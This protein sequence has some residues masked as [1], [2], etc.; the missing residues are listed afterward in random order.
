MLP[1]LLVVA[2]AS[3]DVNS[4][5]ASGFQLDDDGSCSDSSETCLSLLQRRGEKA[6]KHLINSNSVQEEVYKPVRLGAHSDLG[7]A[8]PCLCLFDTD[9]TLTA[10]QR[11][12]FEP[13]YELRTYPT[14]GLEAVDAVCDGSLSQP[15]SSDT[16]YPRNFSEAP[17]TMR[18]SGLTV[19]FDD[20]F[21]SK[22]CYKGILS[23]G[24]IGG[25]LLHDPRKG[26][27]NMVETLEF[28]LNKGPP[29]FRLPCSLGGNGKECSIDALDAL[30]ATDA[31]LKPFIINI[32]A[33]CYQKDRTL[34]KFSGVCKVDFVKHVIAY[35]RKYANI[36]IPDENVHFYDDA[37]VNVAAFRGSKYRAHQIACARRQCWMEPKNHPDVNN[38]LGVCGATL[39]EIEAS[40]TGP[41][42]YLC[43]VDKDGNCDATF[44]CG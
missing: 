29:E 35:Y 4:E 19:N 37:C 6:T 3:V 11:Y 32:G 40:V 1:A 42:F 7:P 38:N 36:E 39:Q 34:G 17:S 5:I 33:A 14:D 41:P 8:Q 9:R 2:N 43:T 20:S 26:Y 28:H 21:C 22:Y 27:R 31:E 15:L 10:I 30:N 18:L 44:G 13:P 12:N 23:V 24:S 25:Q 16:A